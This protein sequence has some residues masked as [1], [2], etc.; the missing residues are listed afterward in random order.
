MP[1]WRS[2]DTGLAA[3]AWNMAV[4]EA[5]LAAAAAGAP[6]TV[7]L[8]GW[9]PPAVTLGYAQRADREL[10]L[11]ACRAAGVDVVRRVTGGR[12]VLHWNEVTY[13]VICH[14]SE[15]R[16]AGTIE[17]S[18]RRIA[19]CLAAGMRTLGVPVELERGAR[20]R[21][22]ASGDAG[23]R[24]PCFASTA[25]WEVSAKGRKLIGSAQRRVQGA[26]L[27]H[28]SVLIGP[29]HRDLLNLLAGPP[30]AGTADLTASSTDLT[31]CLGRSPSYA[32]VAAHLI[33]GFQTELSVDLEPQ[34]LSMAERERANDLVEAKYGDPEFTAGPRPS[35]PVL[36]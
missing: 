21:R 25:R 16:L 17:E 2:T 32:E 15:A 9:Q 28:G 1:I 24:H 33:G 26:L 12:A 22:E 29:E 8:Y 18:H 36:S 3:G 34:P 7:R 6:P 30:P 31:E 23:L 4:D 5:L 20:Q 14:E 13:S 27:Q 35:G 19:Q 11:A 10:N